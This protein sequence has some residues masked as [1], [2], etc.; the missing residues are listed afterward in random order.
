M[1]GECRRFNRIKEGDMK[2]VVNI[3]HGRRQSEFVCLKAN[4]FGYLKWAKAFP[5]KLLGRTRG[6]DV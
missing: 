5:I 3:P 4:A 2:G 6:G 1:G